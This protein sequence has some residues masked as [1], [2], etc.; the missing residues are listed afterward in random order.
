MTQD[1][2]YFFVTVFAIGSI[3]KILA[4]KRHQYRFRLLKS[5]IEL[6][7]Q[8]LFELYFR[9]PET[10][11]ERLQVYYRDA[12]YSDLDLI[13]YRNDM[14]PSVDGLFRLRLDFG[15]LNNDISHLEPYL[16][17]TVRG[18]DHLR[19]SI[20][21]GSGDNDSFKLVNSKQSNR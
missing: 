17:I 19:D 7:I 3:V 1:F 4:I 13:T 15:D 20:Y 2:M 12:F 9:S 8:N 18:F 6:E 11:R 14:M 21:E 10:F 16:R 5:A